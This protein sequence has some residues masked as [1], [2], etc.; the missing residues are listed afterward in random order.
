LWFYSRVARGNV[1]IRLTVAALQRCSRG[2]VRA[3]DGT[4]FR[5][6]DRDL[7][8][9]NVHSTKV[10]AAAALAFFVGLLVFASSVEACVQCRCRS[11]FADGSPGPWGDWF[12][13]YNA[14]TCANSCISPGICLPIPCFPIKKLDS[15]VGGRLPA[16]ACKRGG[17][18]DRDYCHPTHGPGNAC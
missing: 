2:L 17:Y 5:G 8:E 9:G 13:T 10:Y 3:I 14:E 7:R 16:S 6:S 12:A 11:L 4:N 1:P 15:Q 18:N